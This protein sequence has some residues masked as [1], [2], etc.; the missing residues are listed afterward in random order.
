MSD[1]TKEE[2]DLELTMRDCQAGQREISDQKYAGK[3]EFSL[4]QKIVFS[5]I[6]LILVAVVGALLNLVITK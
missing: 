1:K 6:T 5:I 4:I 2:L 3:A